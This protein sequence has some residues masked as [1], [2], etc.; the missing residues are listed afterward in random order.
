MYRYSLALITTIGFVANIEAQPRTLPL[1]PG[2]RPASPIGP[3]TQFL[4]QPV[5]QVH[6]GFGSLGRT[7][8]ARGIGFS[9]SAYY[10]YGFGY[11]LGY[12][13]GYGFGYPGPYDGYG[14]VPPVILSPPRV[15]PAPTVVLANE[16][17]ATLTVQFPAAADVWLNG[18]A[19]PGAAAEERVLTSRVLKPGEQFAFG[20]KGRWTI[21]GKTFESTRNV[22]LGAGDRS[23]LLIVSGT[24]VK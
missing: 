12:G 20:V 2:V 9:R 23:R 14:Y 21:D 11:G 24:E 10:G 6:S 15:R 13:Y 19:V 18:V 8:A 17:P 4:P 3:G 22:T 7:H 5:P 1:S 16:F